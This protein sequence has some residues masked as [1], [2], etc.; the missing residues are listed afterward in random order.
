M[1]GQAN[2][3]IVAVSVETAVVMVYGS[4][5][6]TIELMLV[7]ETAVAV[8]SGPAPDKLLLVVETAMMVLW[9]PAL[10]NIAAVG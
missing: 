4:A 5:P 1:C 10:G 8:V 2:G 7:V 9:D 6:L 3:N